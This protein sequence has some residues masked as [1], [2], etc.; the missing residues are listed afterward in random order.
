VVD[1]MELLINK[2]GAREFSFQD[3]SVSVD[4]IRLENICKEIIK[5]KI[6]IRWTTPNGIAHWTLNKNLLLLMKKAGCYRI[7]FGIES[8]DPEL[9]RWIGKP[10][11]LAQARELTMYANKIG[12]WTL[13]TNIIGFPYESKE[14]IMNTY[15]FAVESGVDLAFFFRLG[16]REGTSVYDVFKK[17]DWLIKDRHMLFSENVACRTKYFSG[18]EI[19]TMQLRLYRKFLIRRWLTPV[20]IFRVLGK[21]RSW[22]DFRYIIKIIL[23]GYRLTRNLLTTKIGVTS[24]ALSV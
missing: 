20:S 22:E 9:R 11:S 19:V 10:Y 6:D 23:A 8:G 24:K 21:I 5:R 3:D 7:T 1:E 14:M 4:K 15:N 2:Y 16:P 18:E 12:L 17:E 13:A